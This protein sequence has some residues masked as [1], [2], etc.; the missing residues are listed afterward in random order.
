M[1]DRI[2]QLRQQCESARIAAN[3]LREEYRVA[4]ETNAPITYQKPL[5]DAAQEASK[6]AE[7][8]EVE[9]RHAEFDAH[10]DTSGANWRLRNDPMHQGKTADMIALARMTAAEDDDAEACLDAAGESHG[11]DEFE[12]TGIEMH[13]ELYRISD[14]DL[15]F[16]RDLVDVKATA[17]EALLDI[18]DFLLAGNSTWR[19]AKR[20]HRSIEQFAESYT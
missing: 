17:D 15:A 1:I 16:E 5:L 20:M 7:D 14:E 11:G 2:E 12:S 3:K 19:A 13:D 8:C 6:A 4:F 10:I 18:A 9:L